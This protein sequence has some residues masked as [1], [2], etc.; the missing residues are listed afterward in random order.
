[1]RVDSAVIA[2]DMPQLKPALG[3]C[4]TDRVESLAVHRGDNHVGRG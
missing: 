4:S 1:M 3:V 2:E